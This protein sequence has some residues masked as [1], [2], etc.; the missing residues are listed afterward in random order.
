[1]E[2]FILLLSSDSPWYNL[3]FNLYNINGEKNL[4]YNLNKKDKKGEYFISS[5][6]YKQN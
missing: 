5:S 1:M 4:M 2:L 6:F 3:K